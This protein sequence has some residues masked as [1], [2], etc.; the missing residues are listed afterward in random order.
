MKTMPGPSEPKADVL[1]LLV[2]LDQADLLDIADGRGEGEPELRSAMAATRARLVVS[3][4]HVMDLAA[5]DDATCERWI[6]AVATFGAVD[7]CVEPGNGLAC[8][9][10]ELQAHVATCRPMFVLLRAFGD[11][12]ETVDGARREDAKAR[13]SARPTRRQAEATIDAI[14]DPERVDELLA[15]PAGRDDAVRLLV[16]IKAAADE[17]GLSREWML[18]HL[19]HTVPRARERGDLATLVEV[20]RRVDRFRPARRSDFT[21]ELHVRFGLCADVFTVDGNVGHILG[22]IDGQPIPLPFGRDPRRVPVVV[23]A[24]VRSLSRV[25]AIVSRLGTERATDPAA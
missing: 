11:W 14:L 10:S 21:D 7:F 16:S 3:I 19:T 5:A 15:N 12:I 22:T 13:P 20:H 23:R 2:Y 1:D 6:D 4:A 24:E 18:G 8:D 25:A 9:C 17:L